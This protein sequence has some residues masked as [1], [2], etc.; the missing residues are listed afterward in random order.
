M[1]VAYQMVRGQGGRFTKMTKIE[2]ETPKAPKRRAYLK[3]WNLSRS[4]AQIG[5]QWMRLCGEVYGHPSFVD[6]DVI[7]T[8]PILV[9]DIPGG[10]AETMHTVY[11]LKD[12]REGK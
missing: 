11:L 8:S 7:T 1:S 9:L 12:N 5:T 10:F 3:N 4:A 6:G 2:I